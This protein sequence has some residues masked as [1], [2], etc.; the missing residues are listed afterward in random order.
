MAARAL[1]S[2]VRYPSADT[3]HAR[4]IRSH[5]TVALTQPD[6]ANMAEPGA[7]M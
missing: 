2:G 3:D 7:C 4:T 1:E 5:A 6:G